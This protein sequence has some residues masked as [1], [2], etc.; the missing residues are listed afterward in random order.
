MERGMAAYQAGDY[1]Q[2][3]T[4]LSKLVEDDPNQIEAKL[5]LG[6]SMVAQGERERA[7]FL[8]KRVLKETHDPTIAAYAQ[9]MLTQLGIAVE[10]ASPPELLRPLVPREMS[11][12]QFIYDLC[13]LPDVD[14]AEVIP[15]LQRYVEDIPAF[16]AE[17][18]L[19]FKGT[20]KG[21]CV[22]EGLLY[23]NTPRR[24]QEC[25][26]RL[27]TFLKTPDRV[28]EQ[29]LGVYWRSMIPTQQV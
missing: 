4:L 7:V 11:F 10:E 16:R 2:A 8:F 22:L 19:G 27:Q 24:Q 9:E 1:A 26:S 12:Q 29:V 18:A 23:F 28:R 15:W 5:W 17:L 21:A 14:L 25:Q 6:A 3:V 13:L 20:E